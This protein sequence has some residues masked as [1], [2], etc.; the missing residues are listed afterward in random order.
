VIVD[1]LKDLVGAWGEEDRELAKKLGVWDPHPF[2]VNQYLTDLFMIVPENIGR[3][4]KYPPRFAVAKEDGLYKLPDKVIFYKQK[5]EIVPKGHK[6]T[7]VRLSIDLAYEV[8]QKLVRRGCCQRYSLRTS[9]KLDRKFGGDPVCG[10]GIKRLFAPSSTEKRAAKDLQRVLE[11]GRFTGTTWLHQYFDFWSDCSYRAEENSCRIAVFVGG[12]DA[13]M[14]H[15][16]RVADPRGKYPYY[17]D[18]E[19]LEKM[20]DWQREQEERS[21]RGESF[22]LVSVPEFMDTKTSKVRF[23]I[24]S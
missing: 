22:T 8:P 12:E 9:V 6:V 15:I 18:D 7:G 2:T 24:V 1:F 17:L 20:K 4:H 23:E 16:K 5:P 14:R 21:K 13:V 3:D 10:G 11:R 19:G